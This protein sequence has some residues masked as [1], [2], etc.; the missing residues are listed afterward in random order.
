MTEYEYEYYSATQ[1]WPDT[2]TNIIWIPNNDQIQLSF[3]LPKMIEYYIQI[4]I[5]V[6]FPKRSYLESQV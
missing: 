5:L 3:G 6:S 2:N 4:Q 1:T